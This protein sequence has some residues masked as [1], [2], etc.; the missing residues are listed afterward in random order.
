[1]FRYDCRTVGFYTKIGGYAGSSTRTE[2][3][4]AV[5]AISAH[6]PVHFASDSQTMVKRAKYY[7]SLI[8][9]GRT[10]R[11][12]FAVSSDGDLWEH[13]FKAAQAKSAQSIEISWVKGHATEQHVQKGVT[14]QDDKTGNDQADEV[15]DMGAKL[16]A[17]DVLQGC[18]SLP[19]RS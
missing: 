9:K 1:M 16:Y 6:D 11:K 14:T 19:Y 13:F 2:L 7:I 5:L 18:R 15:A 8:E 3:A 4:A 17:D 12:P 10:P